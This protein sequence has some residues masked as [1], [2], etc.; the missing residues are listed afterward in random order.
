MT[1]QAIAHIA[2]L[3][4][5]EGKTRAEAAEALGLCEAYVVRLAKDNDVFLGK[6][7]SP[8]RALV[9]RLRPLAAAGF[10]MQEAASDIGVSYV[11]VAQL[12]AKHDIKFIRSGLALEPTIREQQMAALYR[13]GKTLR[14]KNVRDF[15]FDQAI[16]IGRIVRLFAQSHCSIPPTSKSLRQGCARVSAQ[17]NTIFR[18]NQDF[19]A[20][21]ILRTPPRENYA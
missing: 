11:Y 13:S 10:T 16:K 12:S 4:T 9:E 3:R 15:V 8:T 19:L 17:R 7:P 2:K 14:E 20:A 5:L 6:K 18:H 1:G 21:G